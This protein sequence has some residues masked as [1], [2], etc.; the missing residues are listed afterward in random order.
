MTC[1]LVTSGLE[2]S[3]CTLIINGVYRPLGLGL[4][5]NSLMNADEYRTLKS[6]ICKDT[7]VEV[8]EAYY[9]SKINCTK[10]M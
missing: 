6:S 7:S 8:R 10:C 3:G 5:F 2:L 4:V 1:A 9:G